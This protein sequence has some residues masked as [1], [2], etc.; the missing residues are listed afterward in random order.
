MMS[1][2]AKRVCFFVYM[3]E[4]YMVQTIYFNGDLI[5]MTGMETNPEALVTEGRI[6]SYIGS[7]SEAE[8]RAQADTRYVDLNGKTLM[9]AFI[10]PHS[11]IMEKAEF[12]QYADLSGCQSFQ[13]IVQVLQ[14][15]MKT[16]HI[17][18]DGV[19]VGVG[20]DHNALREGRHPDKYVLD[21]VSRQIPI[22]IRHASSHM[23]VGNS[24]MMELAGI[25]DNTPDP[26]GAK[27]G[28]V[29]AAGEPN[30]YTEELNAMAYCYTVIDSRTA[31]D[32]EILLAE[33]Q[34]YYLSYGIT[35][36]Q[37]GATNRQSFEILKRL[38][39]QGKFD[40]DIV[41]YIRSD[42]NP[43]D[44]IEKNPSYAKGYRHR[45]K[46]GGCKNFLDGSPQGKTAWLS[47]PY[48]GETSYCGYAA[49]SDKQLTE[50][51]LTAI[52]HGRQVLSHC[53]G[54]A[55]ADQYIRCYQKALVL[56]RYPDKMCLRPVMVHCQTVR[57]DQL[58]AMVPLHMIPSF[59]V[60]HTYYWG[61]VHLKN[62]GVARGSRISPVREA[63]ER[64]LIYNFH[65]DTPVVSA[66][67]LHSVWAA[68]NR[69]TKNGVSIGPEW[70]I[71]VYDALKGITCYAAYAYGEE[72]NKGTLEEG[73]L[74]DLVILDQNPLKVQPIAIQDIQVMETIK[75]GCSLY[76]RKHL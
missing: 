39:E 63:L 24:R 40:I 13:D 5:T 15:H 27:F 19:V 70:R 46:I 54:D 9:P 1:A 2:I 68:V 14:E 61:D 30:G 62:L 72:K 4:G 12:F 21:A 67:M 33:A 57:E 60:G 18:E 36:A 49:M 28:R 23:G 73:K 66:D 31:A 25:H 48:E 26:E 47:Q 34:Q 51:L 20:Y 44:M 69:I 55:A 3:E 7:L 8:M 65:R 52:D 71:S 35:T 75:E 17:G 37:D 10:D 53:N 41:C 38:A 43:E 29:T 42:E 74:A 64:G 76:Q 50:Y 22:Y 11:H 59:F 16:R 6:I 58:E 56:S 45:L 32:W